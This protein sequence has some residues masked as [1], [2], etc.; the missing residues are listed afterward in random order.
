MP[1]LRNGRPVKWENWTVEDSLGSK[2]CIIFHAKF[3]LLE[4]GLILLDLLDFRDF[5]P[6]KLGPNFSNHLYNIIS[7]TSFTKGPDRPLWHASLN[8]LYVI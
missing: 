4:E 2:V 3:V 1:P 8:K 7:I 5:G 6:P